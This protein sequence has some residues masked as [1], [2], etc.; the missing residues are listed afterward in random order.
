MP[1]NETVLHADLITTREVETVSTH[2]TYCKVPELQ[3]LVAQE[4]Q[5]H[6]A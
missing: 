1:K 3:Q 4:D 5:Q 2:S 6:G